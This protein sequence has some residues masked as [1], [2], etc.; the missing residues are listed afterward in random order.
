MVCWVSISPQFFFG[1]QVDG[2]EPLAVAAQPSSSV[3]TA[4]TSGSAA[5]GAML[6]EPRDRV[7]LDL[8][9][10]ADF[11]RDVGRAGAWR[12]RR[13][14]RRARPLRVRAS[15]S[16]SSAARAAR[17]A[18]GERVLGFGQPVGGGAARGF[19]GSGPRRSAARRFSAK[20]AGASAS[21]ARS[22][23]ASALRGVERRD[24]ARRR[25]L[26]GRSRPAGRSRWR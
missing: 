24:L 10:L 16:A 25:G 3:S 4:A 19:G 1:A 15:P 6:G 18:G 21:D 20:I 8:E 13:A 12:L 7:G 9:H 2:A 5:S 14:P 23:L 17:S 26:C 22:C 11:M